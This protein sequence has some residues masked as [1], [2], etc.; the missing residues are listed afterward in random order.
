VVRLLARF[1][2]CRARLHSIS[3]LRRELAVYPA[4][5]SEVNIFNTLAAWAAPKSPPARVR[6]PVRPK[7]SYFGYPTVWAKMTF[8]SGPRLSAWVSDS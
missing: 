3:P 5:N 4:I 8:W 2:R 1:S 7:W 6:N